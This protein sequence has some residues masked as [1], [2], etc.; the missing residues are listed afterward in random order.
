MTL[1][2]TVV[3]SVMLWMKQYL[4][5]KL[6]TTLLPV[7]CR[8]ASKG[9]FYG[10]RHFGFEIVGEGFIYYYATVPVSLVDVVKQAV[11]SAY[12]TARLEEVVEHNILI[13]SASS[14]R[15]L[16]VN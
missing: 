11:N 16:V 1:K 13:K 14:T 2:V 4:K 15:W 10:Q 7:R 5:H 8:K 9:K 6:F 12:P 3:T